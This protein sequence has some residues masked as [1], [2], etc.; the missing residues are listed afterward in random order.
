[1]KS[2]G[3]RYQFLRPVMPRAATEVNLSRVTGGGGFGNFP[4][5]PNTFESFF[6]VLPVSPHMA[7]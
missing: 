2:S 7:D 3:W 5:L 1:V 6:G 4:P